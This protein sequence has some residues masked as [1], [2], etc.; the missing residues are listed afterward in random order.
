M[1]EGAIRQS[2]LL[3][4]AIEACIDRAVREGIGLVLEGSHFI[5]GVLDPKALGAD[6]LCIL[7]APDRET[8]KFRALSPNH[9]QRRL[10]DEQIGRLFQLQ[11]SI[12]RL[13]QIDHQPVVINDDVS[14][15]VKQIRSLL[16]SRDNPTRPT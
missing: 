9:S 7:D 10:S 2:V 12:L 4:P 15:T 3:R 13:A 16:E 14:E 1:L 11:D 6:I 5:P 8:L